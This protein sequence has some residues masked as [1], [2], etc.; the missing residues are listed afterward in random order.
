[1]KGFTLKQIIKTICLFFLSLLLAGADQF[2]KYIIS[3]T[4]EYRTGYITVIPG[5]FEL[6]NWHN[7]GGMWGLFPGQVG[8]LAYIALAVTLVILFVGI[9]LKPFIPQLSVF[10]IVAGAI[11]NIIDR[12]RLKYVVDFLSFNFWGYHFPAF[13]IADSCVVIGALLLIFYMLFIAKNDTSMFIE[14]SLPYN[15]THK[16]KKNKQESEEDA[17]ENDEE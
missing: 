16:M 1:M 10:L 5:F 8:P 7:D 17:K 15:L 14:G 4:I 12:F 3:N 6:V 9:F 13:N 2:V 11:G